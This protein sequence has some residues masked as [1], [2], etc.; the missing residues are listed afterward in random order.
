[1]VSNV[2]ITEFQIQARLLCRGEVVQ[3]IPGP[4][5]L[6]WMYRSYSIAGFLM[7]GHG[8][9]LN[10]LHFNKLLCNSYVP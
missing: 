5:C 2:Y 3:S 4:C 6:V 1:M 10:A 9:M 7:S 8:V